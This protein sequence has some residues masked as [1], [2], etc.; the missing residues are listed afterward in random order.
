MPRSRKTQVSLDAP[1]ITIA[2]HAV[3]VVLFCAVKMTLDRQCA[4][5]NRQ[6]IEGESP[7]SGKA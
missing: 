7:L 2:A 6:K 1:P 4:E 3:F 5:I